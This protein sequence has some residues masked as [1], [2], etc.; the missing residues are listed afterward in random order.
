MQQSTADQF[1]V[2]SDSQ[3]AAGIDGE[4]AMLDPP[5]RFRIRPRRATR[6]DLAPACRGV[7]VG[8]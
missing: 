5:L 2:G 3:V 8:A 6:P 1:E 4:A 7:T